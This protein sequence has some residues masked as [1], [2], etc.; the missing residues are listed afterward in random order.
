[1]DYSSATITNKKRTASFEDVNMEAKLRN[2]ICSRR[3]WQY[4]K[5]GLQLYRKE[6]SVPQNS[7]KFTILSY[8]VLAQSLLEEHKYLYKH[9]DYRVLQWEKRAKRILREVKD[10]AADILCLQ[11]VEFDAFNNFFQPQLSILGF[12]GVFKKRT[13]D[14]T[15]GCAIF[16]RKS[17]FCIF[18]MA[19]LFYFC[20]A[21]TFPFSC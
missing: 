10:T 12:E 5:Y 11:E 20:Y 15:D 17:K 18:S 6:V 4:T 16:Y 21:K 13:G 9:C 19:T 3:Y 8:N 14:K 2:C 1:M 7:L